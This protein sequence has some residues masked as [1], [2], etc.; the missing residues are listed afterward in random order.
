V[1]AL[2]N[3][4]V[5]DVSA[6]R[7]STPQ[8]LRIDGDAIADIDAPDP[9]AG[10]DWSD[11]NVIDVQG[12]TV[13]PG[14]VEAHVHIGTG[15]HDATSDSV[16]MRKAMADFLA[17]GYTTVRDLGSVGS[18]MF[19]LRAAIDANQLVGPRLVLCG[20]VISAPCPGAAAFPGMYVE[21][22]GAR[23]AR[24]AATAQVA[25]GADLVKVMVTGALTVAEEDVNPAQLNLRALRAIVAEARSLGVPT[26]AHAEGAEG[27]RLAVAAGFD[28]IEHGEMAYLMPDVLDEMARRGIILVPTLSVFEAV[29][30][31]VAHGFP[32]WMR[33][34]ANHLAE[35]ARRTVT[36]ARKAGVLI[37][38]GAD[39][40]PHGRNARELV[41]LAEAG[42]T[43]GEA[44]LAGTLLAARACGL[45]QTLGS[46]EVG[47]QADLVVLDGNPLTDLTSVVDRNRIKLVMRAGRIVG[48]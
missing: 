39:A 13:M 10:T 16:L 15:A 46:V 8:T 22:R 20:Q 19:E 47:K 17:G 32:P 3:A 11:L 44:L 2:T 29:A 9:A 6:G 5:L 42:L 28:S 21:V 38:A 37:A 36:A 1:I 7:L 34:R 45:D 23:E 12:A 30:D 14:L 33:D 18:T 24:A 4:R 26:A 43:T 31:P 27:V 35:S 25:R 48:P 40:P 41:H